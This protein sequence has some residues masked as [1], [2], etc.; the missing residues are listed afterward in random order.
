MRVDILVNELEREVVDPADHVL[1]GRVDHI[2]GGGD[3]LEPDG[4]PR[5]EADEDLEGPGVDVLDV[6]VPLPVLGHGALQ[7]G[8]E[9]RAPGHR[10]VCK[11]SVSFDLFSSFSL[12]PLPFSSFISPPPPPS[13]TSLRVE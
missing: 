11:G 3:R 8:A 4:V 1:L 10:R 12:H 9:H 13:L 7:H 5:H 2:E 6:D